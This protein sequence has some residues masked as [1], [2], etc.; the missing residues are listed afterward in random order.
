[1]KKLIEQYE[2]EIGRIVKREAQLREGLKNRSYPAEEVRSVERRLDF[3]I[4]ERY[5][6]MHSLA[7]MRKHCAPKPLSPSLAARERER[8]C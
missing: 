1:M 7:L 5:D 8:T 4:C 3:L 2:D 6:L